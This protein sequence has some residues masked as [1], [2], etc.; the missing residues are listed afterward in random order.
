MKT[1]DEF[2]LPVYSQSSIDVGA[3]SLILN[4][5]SDKLQIMG[6]KLADNAGTPMLYNVSGDELRTGWF[7][8]DNLT[9]KAGDK[10]LTL[11]V[12]LIGSLE[13]NE[14]I[15]FTLAADQLTNLPMPVAPLFRMPC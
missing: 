6:V 4:F 10:L 13:Q 3:V 11:R 7:S 14:T 12:K 5:P 8:S 9:L 15:R 2:D 1:G